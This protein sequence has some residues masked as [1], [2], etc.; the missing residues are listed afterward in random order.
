MD[1]TPVPRHHV[2]GVRPWQQGLNRFYQRDIEIN[3][4]SS[5]NSSNKSVN[6]GNDKENGDM[7]DTLIERKDLS[8][9]KKY[10]LTVQLVSGSMLKFLFFTLLLCS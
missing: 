5:S 4:N 6:N 9:D 8:N 2:F 1:Y 10:V 3:N 7:I